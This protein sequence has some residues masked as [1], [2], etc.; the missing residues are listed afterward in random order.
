M[1]VDPTNLEGHL[2]DLSIYGF[3]YQVLEPIPQG[4]QGTTVY[5]IQTSAKS[6]PKRIKINE[7][8]QRKKHILDIEKQR[9]ELIRLLFRCFTNK[10]R[11]LK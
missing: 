3:Q 9:S 8:S 1:D 2:W 10:N 5:H 11:V 6:K 7:R 4:Y